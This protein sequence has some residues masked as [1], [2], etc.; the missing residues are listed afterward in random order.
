MDIFWKKFEEKR[1]K[2]EFEEEHKNWLLKVL[3]N[4][5]FFVLHLFAY[6]S[7]NG[8]LILIFLLS[9]RFTG[10][11]YFW[12]FN[13][14]FGWG[15][16]MGFHALSYIMYNEK[17]EY[18]TYIKQQSP[19]IVA[20]IYHAFF[21]I[22]VNLFLF[23]LNL[24]D[25]TFIWFT[26]SLGMWGIAFG[27]HAIGFFT[28][29]KIFYSQWKILRP[30]FQ[31]YSKHKLK[32]KIIL[33]IGNFWLLLIHI[34]YFFV[35]FIIVHIYV[36]VGTGLGQVEQ[37]LILEIF[38]GWGIYL[39]LHAFGYILF[40]HIESI[41]T[42]VKGLILHISIY[43]VFNGRYIYEN[44]T[45]LNYWSW[46]ILIYIMILWAIGIVIH[47]IIALKWNK[48]IEKEQ[49]KASKKRDPEQT[50]RIEKIWAEFLGMKDTP[51]EPSREEATQE[52]TLIL[53]DDVR[54]SVK[55]R[56]FWKWSLIVHLMNYIA[57]I[58]IISINVNIL[59]LDSYII[60]HTAFGWG[61][62][63]AAHSAIYIIVL[64]P[65]KG[66]WATTAFLH[67]V[68]FIIVNVYLVVINLIYA[69]SIIWFPY[70]LI[71][72][73]IGLGIHILI[74]R[75]VRREKKKEREVKKTKGVLFWQWS[76]TIHIFIYLM[77][78]GIIS[79][80]IIANRE[81]FSALFH[82]AMGWGIGIAIH[83]AIFYVVLK[84]I[85]RFLDY[86]AFIHLI[87]YIMVS[88]YLVLLN[89]IY[90]PTVIWSPIAIGGWGIGIGFHILL[91]HLTKK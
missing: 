61:I 12:P 54:S 66:F 71:G 32:H 34:T 63:V 14:L 28:W 52:L 91:A 2:G 31:D 74:T 9:L 78:L 53:E 19:Y 18:L 72:W 24:I 89:I 82:T 77:V 60:L 62:G 50:K 13:T 20:F 23:L 67:T 75:A 29:N 68:V 3:T 48:L 33:K 65:I 21:Y 42:S 30:K 47:A 38:L 46:L 6:C 69:P 25:L 26:W 22:S 88:V 43:A 8:F 49:A 79:I 59:R 80:T 15:F 83:G 11:T 90:S 4:R 44:I 57:V 17:S 10:L 84:P 37:F 73:G 64:K 27:Y 5:S 55:S 45:Y 16:G 70:P 76:L 7:V 36:F 58:I 86:T 81:N 87:T 1:E 85:K 51:E 39:V 56:I 41:T 35:A 40:Y